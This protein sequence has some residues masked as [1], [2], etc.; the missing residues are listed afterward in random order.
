MWFAMSPYLPE[1][2]T[3]S[4][5]CIE[6]RQTGIFTVATP[7]MAHLI[8]AVRYQRSEFRYP[9][10]L[11]LIQAIFG[12]TRLHRLYD[13]SAGAVLLDSKAKWGGTNTANMIIPATNNSIGVRLTALRF[14]IACLT[15]VAATSTCEFVN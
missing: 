13:E 6:S 12:H 1:Y 11:T 14:G 10:R 2:Y 5:G 8:V 9:V 15:N 7:S 4:S 3:H